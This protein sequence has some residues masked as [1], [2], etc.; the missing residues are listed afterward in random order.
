MVVACQF[1][2]VSGFMLPVLSWSLAFTHMLCAR[3]AGLHVDCY[4]HVLLQ[5]CHVVSGMHLGAL[6]TI[7]A[8]VSVSPGGAADAGISGK[9]LV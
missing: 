8:A 7:V 4:S 6:H 2:P 5:A 9:E 3:A 1:V